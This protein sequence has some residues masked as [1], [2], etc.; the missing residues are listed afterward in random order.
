[1]RRAYGEFAGDAN[2]LFAADLVID[3]QSGQVTRGDQ[4]LT[5]TPLEFRLLVYF[6]QNA[7]QALTRNQILDAVWGYDS[8]IESDK[9]INVHIR[10]LR[11]KIE[12]D[13]D[14]PTLLLTV[15]GV[16]YRLRAST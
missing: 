11:Q 1:L 14:R 6:A 12:P 15:P 3:R 16:G 7:G 10:R 5:L 2:L 9:V 8:D 4:V 13:P